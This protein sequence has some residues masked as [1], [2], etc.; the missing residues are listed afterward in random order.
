MFADEL[1]V[2]KQW[3]QQIKTAEMYHISKDILGL[4]I[5]HSIK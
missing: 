2:L 1:I 3:L 4:L 5:E